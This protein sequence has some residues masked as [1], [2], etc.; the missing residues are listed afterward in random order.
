MNKEGYA[1]PPIH[2]DL[3]TKYALPFSPWIQNPGKNILITCKVQ[4]PGP[5]NRWICNPLQLQDPE[6][7]QNLALNPKS[8]QKYFQNLSICSSIH[9]PRRAFTFQ[10]CLLVGRVVQRN[11]KQ[12]LEN[13]EG[14]KAVVLLFNFS[15]EQRKMWKHSSL[16]FPDNRIKI[17]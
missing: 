8:G 7:R 14:L 15:E 10:S 9:L 5:K 12:T 4:N 1:N 13:K 17:G 11:N 3:L 6:I 2:Y 16:F